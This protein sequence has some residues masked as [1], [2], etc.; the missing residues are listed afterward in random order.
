MSEKVSSAGKAEE[1]GRKKRQAIIEAARAIFARQGYEATTIAEIAAA[2]GVAVGTVYLYFRNK[3]EVYIAASLVL[4]SDIA[5]VIVQPEILQLPIQQVPRVLIE[6]SFQLCHNN[7]QFMPI[8]QVNVQG[9]K[10]IEMHQEG[11]Q[12]IIQ[13]LNAFFIHCIKRGDFLPFDTEMY[14]KIIFNL[15]DSVLYDCFCI[16]AGVNEELYRKRTIEIVER[17]FFGPSLQGPEKSSLD[18]QL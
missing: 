3:R 16:E 10:E 2:A 17:I 8:F 1:A 9:Q 15:V 12:L 4:L 14:A 5:E 18:L 11:E 6:K 13:A 7:K